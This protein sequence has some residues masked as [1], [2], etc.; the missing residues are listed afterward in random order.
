MHFYK[1][2]FHHISRRL[3]IL[4]A[5]VIILIVLFITFLALYVFIAGPEVFQSRAANI[6]AAL[7]ICPTT[8]CVS[9]PVITS[10]PTVTQTP[11]GVT[12][13]LPGLIVGP[14]TQKDIF[15]IPEEGIKPYITIISVGGEDAVPGV[16]LQ[17][18]S[19]EPEIVG[20]TNLARAAIFLEFK[21]F[22]KRIFTIFADSQG[23]WKFFTPL[24][25]GLGDQT[26]FATAVSPF[27]PYFRAQEEFHFRIIPIPKGTPT[28]LIRPHPAE[29]FEREPAQDEEKPRRSPKEG[30][31]PLNIAPTKPDFTLPQKNLFSLRLEVSPFSKIVYPGDFVE[32]KTDILRIAPIIVGEEKHPL[33]VYILNPKLE[34]IFEKTR[35]VKIDAS[36]TLQTRYI[37]SPRLPHGIYGIV[38]ELSDENISYITTDTFEVV[39]KVLFHLPG[40]IITTR[41]VSD[42]IFQILLILFVLL[43]IFFILLLYERKKSKKSAHINEWDLFKDKDIM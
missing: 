27:N 32:V 34:K 12:G 18:Y 33:R 17:T 11:G 14:I 31:M 21:G 7:E 42:V 41:D 9:P 30:I 35:S 29:V 22:E 10:E 39:E 36:A 4:R 13:P 3:E 25:L 20:V 1:D 5:A 2:S 6:L 23:N 15:A 28:P 19:R 40:I 26:F 37:T 24:N 38:A 8:G 43:V 16:L